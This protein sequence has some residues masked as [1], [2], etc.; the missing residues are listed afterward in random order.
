[1]NDV[2]KELPLDRETDGIGRLIALAFTSA[3]FRAVKR[4]EQSST[5][6]GR[7]QRWE[8]ICGCFHNF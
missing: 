7:A 6:I 1:L 4:G 5:N 3:P 2:L 8:R